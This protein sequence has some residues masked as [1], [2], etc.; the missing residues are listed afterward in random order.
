MTMSPLPHD[1]AQ[2][3]ESLF[4]EG[5]FTAAR[6]V[7]LS[8]LSK[9]WK[10]LNTLVAL[11]YFQ[12]PSPSQADRTLALSWFEKAVGQGET[13]AMVLLGRA[14]LNGELGEQDQV[15]GL[16]LL[17]QA[18]D[19]GDGFAAYH[20]AMAL[21]SG[22][23]VQ[24]NAAQAF[25]YLNKAAQAGVPQA[26]HN[27]GACYQHGQ[28]VPV[29]SRLAVAYYEQAARLGSPLSCLALAVLNLEGGLLEKNA[30]MALAWLYVYQALFPQADAPEQLA[31]VLAQ[32]TVEETMFARQAAEAF[33]RTELKM[34][35][36]SIKPS[37]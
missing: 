14:L 3:L 23:H 29:N 11:T 30:G 13:D 32:A 4:Q 12:Q 6:E 15:R 9:P 31:E 16:A 24:A 8:H 22:Q 33:L 19:E 2:Q 5:A 17:M 18:A 27:L 21:Q 20:V 1:F 35:V 10:G 7:L 25:E 26:M 28:G 37:H 36:A 34:P